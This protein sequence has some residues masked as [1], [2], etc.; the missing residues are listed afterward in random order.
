MT[1]TSSPSPLRRIFAVRT[2]VHLVFWSWHAVWLL[3]VFF[4]LGPHLLP[5]L[6][7]ATVRGEIPWGITGSAFA[8]MLLPCVT[9]VAGWRLRADHR[10]L[11]GLFY[12]VAGV[13]F[14]LLMVRLFLVREMTA[15]VALLLVTLAAGAAIYTAD[16][17]GRRPEPRGAVVALV[18]YSALLVIGVWIALVMGLYC[19]P[20]VVLAAQAIPAAIFEALTGPHGADWWVRLPVLA[21]FAALAGCC[22]IVVL[23]LPFA[24]AVLYPRAW[25]RG[26]SAWRTQRSTWS[27]ALV[28]TATVAGWLVVFTIVNDQPQREVLAMLDRRP[29]D[30][31]EQA[32][33]VGAQDTIRAGLLNAALAPH[34]YWGA[35]GRSGQVG[36]LWRDA[37]HTDGNVVLAQHAFDA[38]A[39]PLLYDGHGL[40]T[41]EARAKVAYERFFD[42]PLQDGDRQAVIAAVTATYDRD[43]AE[44]GLLDVGRRKVLL[45][46]QDL[47]VTRSGDVAQFE[48]HE[49]YVNQTNERQEVFYYFNLPER[50]V[51][52][53]LWLGDGPDPARRFAYTVAPRGAAQSV[54]REQRRRN[55][56]P[57]LVERVGPRQYRLRIFP[58]LPR[59]HGADAPPMHLWLHWRALADDAG[60]SLPQ[61]AEARNVYWDGDDTVRT[62][63][64]ARTNHDGWLPARIDAGLTRGEHEAVVG[65]HRVRATPLATTGVPSGRLAVVVDTSRSMAEHAGEVRATLDALAARGVAFDLFVAPSP[66]SADSPAEVAPGDFEPA[67]YG[68]HTFEGVLADFATVR[69]DGAYAAVIILTDAGSFAFLDDVAVPPALTRARWPEPIWM[70]HHGGLP[71]AY[72]DELGDLIGR[73][74]GGVATT[75]DEVLVRLHTPIVD[76][77]AWSFEPVAAGATATDDPFTP[78]AA[79]ALIA[80]LGDRSG[81]LDAIHGIASDHSVVSAWSSMI[82]LVDDAQRRALAEAS[83]ADDR[84]DREAESGIEQTTAPT[85]ALEVGGTP[86]PHEWLLLAL[87]AAGLLVMA[88]RR[89]MPL[90]HPA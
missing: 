81:D 41:D 23:G 58:I 75:L 52:T 11:F 80:H 48:L 34:R 29:V 62:I 27:G 42:R 45:T 13:G 17:F 38:L 63:D 67:Y 59:I 10:R 68:G 1:D 54:Y 55:V 39:A 19:L 73:T 2:L 49:V 28:T 22:M 37:F 71:H 16:L 77:Y 21:T 33:R 18:G 70:L 44:A 86:E 85:G 65:G 15:A 7:R 87:A 20:A 31:A 4:G 82:V 50:A 32:A 90:V 69:G 24:V 76:G 64:G 43:E 12:G 88:R 66:W 74:G 5:E 57:A 89:P 56:D 3:A 8:L 40:R 51:V 30:R 46:Q 26:L 84:F 79:G 25:W 61:L 47:V 35:S 60:W 72:R 14:T 9:V 83:K 78:I 53:G 36:R 6:V